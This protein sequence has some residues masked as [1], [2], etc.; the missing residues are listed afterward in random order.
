MATCERCWSLSLGS[1][2][3]YARLLKEEDCTPEQQAGPD[4]KTCPECGRCTLHQH[5]GC[6]MSCDYDPADERA[7][8]GEGEA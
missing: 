8:R 6:C 5:V 4:A 3:R 7:L 2:E 1:S